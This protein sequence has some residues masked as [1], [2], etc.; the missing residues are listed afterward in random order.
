MPRE[1]VHS[2]LLKNLLFEFFDNFYYKIESHVR[3]KIINKIIRCTFEYILMDLI[4]SSSQLH[5]HLSCIF[6]EMK[7]YSLSFLCDVC[8]EVHEHLQ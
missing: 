4:W 2:L 3:T 8:N 7:F 1:L 5:F 6:I